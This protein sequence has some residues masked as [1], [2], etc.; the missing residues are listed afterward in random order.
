MT[1]HLDLC[2]NFSDVFDIVKRSTEHSLKQSRA[3][4]MLY[5]ARLPNHVSAFHPLGSNGIVMNRTVL[6][7]VTRGG[8][9]L[10]EINSYVYSLLLQEYLHALGYVDEEMV[11]KLVHQVSLE[12]FGADHPATRIAAKSPIA[13]FDI[14][15]DLKNIQ[16]TMKD[17]EVVPDLEKS[18]RRYIR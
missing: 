14:H 2:E 4:L 10:R 15:L 5:L 11:R 8:H 1:E 16:P 6:D 18:A 17:F 13:I 12:T 9:S 7:A 3:G